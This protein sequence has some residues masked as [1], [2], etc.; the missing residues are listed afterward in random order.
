M[1]NFYNNTF[2]GS[3]QINEGSGTQVNNSGISAEEVLQ[4]LQA[5][6]EQLVQ[7]PARDE[8]TESLQ[9]IV[10][11]AHST[12]ASSSSSDSPGVISTFVGKLQSWVETAQTVVGTSQEAHALYTSVTELLGT[13]G[14]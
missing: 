8:H 12:L 4:L 5:L 11:D 14:G 2:N 3:V 10:D 1:A 7:L 13:L 6:Q 9:K